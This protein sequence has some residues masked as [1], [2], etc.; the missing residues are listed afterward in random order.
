MPKAPAGQRRAART[1]CEV[2]DSISFVN[3]DGDKRRR[4]ILVKDR[5]RTFWV[6]NNNLKL[7]WSGA[8]PDR[9]LPLSPWTSTATGAKSS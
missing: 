8:G 5:Y 4:E 7:L 3:L 6:Y 1:S 9:P 2:G